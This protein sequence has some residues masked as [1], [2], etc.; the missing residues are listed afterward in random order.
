MPMQARFIGFGQSAHL[1]IAP[2]GVA[3]AQPV[4]QLDKLDCNR[5]HRTEVGQQVEL[6]LVVACQRYATQPNY[7]LPH[8][9]FWCYATQN[10]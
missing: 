8:Y 5:A 7:H 10:V 9:V 2:C 1:N 4:R 6:V 3:Y